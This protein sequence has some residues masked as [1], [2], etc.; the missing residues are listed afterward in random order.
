MGDRR[1]PHDEAVF[2]A[3]LMLGT[4]AQRFLRRSR[5][6]RVI[7]AGLL[8]DDVVAALTSAS[9]DMWMARVQRV[10]AARSAAAASKEERRG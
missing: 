9:D 3:G 1:D 2:L 6:Q 10:S 7:R 4:A 8:D 5:T